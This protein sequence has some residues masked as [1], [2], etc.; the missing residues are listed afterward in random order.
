MLELY[1]WDTPNGRKISIMLEELGLPY[2]TIGININS[3]AQFTPEFTR[4]SPSNKIP[5]LV[6]RETGISLMESGAILMYLAE[7]TRRFLPVN[8]PAKWEVIQWLMFQMGGIGPML[9]QTHHFHFYNPGKAPYAE[10]RYLKEAQRLYSVLERRLSN[11]EC[12]AGEY[13]IADIATWP[14]IAR[15]KRQGID[16]RDFPNLKAWYLRLAARPAVQLGWRVPN[17]VEPIPLPE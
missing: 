6:D 12:L 8:G 13:S 14:W 3:G 11:R 9:G 17:D 2:R 1:T 10:E 7:K 5:A 4:I 16:W 15:Y